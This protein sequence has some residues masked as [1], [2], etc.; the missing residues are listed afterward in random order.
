MFGSQVPISSDNSIVFNFLDYKCH[1][2]K[3]ILAFLSKINDE[4]IINELSPLNDVNQFLSFILSAP[5]MSI[6]TTSN[7]SIYPVLHKFLSPWPNHA[8]YSVVSILKA[9]KDSPLYPKYLDFMSLN[10]LPSL[11]PKGFSIRFFG[12]VFYGKERYFGVLNENRNLDLHSLTDTEKI[13]QT[14]HPDSVSSPN[15][16]LEMTIAEMDLQMMTIPN[17][18]F[19]SFASSISIGKLP[20]SLYSKI[21]DVITS[22][23]LAIL[24]RIVQSKI[25]GIYDPLITVF[26]FA[27]AHRRLLKYCAYHDMNSITDTHQIMRGNSTETKCVIEFVKKQVVQHFAETLTMMKTKLMATPAFAID[28][29]ND[30]DIFIID[31]MISSFIKSI[32]SMLHSFPSSLRFVFRSIYEAG[33]HRFNQ[34]RFGL[35]GVFMVFFFRVIFPL[36]CQPIP[37]DPP[38]MQMNIMQMTKLP[39]VLS[40]LLSSEKSEST[41]HL[42]ATFETQKENI[43]MIYDRLIECDEPHDEIIKPSITEVIHAI[44]TIK[45]K[46]GPQCNNLAYMPLQ[47]SFIIKH[48]LSYLQ[49]L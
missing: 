34:E 31:S 47:P 41:V 43:K 39:K 40:N 29:T 49:G 37:S 9:K 10:L 12:D 17:I 8:I 22:P 19:R 3:D 21:I 20:L 30:D 27:G 18:V 26:T 1:G 5:F 25:E 38:E 16:F 24:N 36:L 23:N 32:M 4:T 7:M 42:E 13:V 48:W 6:L 46:C 28:S 11:E 2:S 14:V 45:T 33:I 44:D 15:S 35:R